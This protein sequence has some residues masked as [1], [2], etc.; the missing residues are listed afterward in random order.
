MDDN[1]WRAEL[2]GKL[3]RLEAKVCERNE[4]LVLAYQGLRERVAGAFAHT[5]NL[6]NHFDKKLNSHR[7]HARAEANGLKSSLAEVRQKLDFAVGRGFKGLETC[8]KALGTQAQL[9][10]RRFKKVRA[11]LR[12]VQHRLCRGKWRQGGSRERS[13]C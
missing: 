9:T 12:E 2:E 6:L 11:E 7:E 3:E 13:P 1:S 10:R 8:R 4:E 5:R